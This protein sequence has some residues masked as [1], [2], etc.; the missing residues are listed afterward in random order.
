MHPYP[1]FPQNLTPNSLQQ[2]QIPQQPPQSQQPDPQ[3]ISALS[4][5]EHS[6]MWQQMNQLQ[7]P[8]RQQQSGDL[9]ASQMNHQASLPCTFF[10]AASAMS[11]KFLCLTFMRCT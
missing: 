11:G 7:N 10:S 4:N 6:R 3:M 5:P 1:M 8:Y 9:A 2:S